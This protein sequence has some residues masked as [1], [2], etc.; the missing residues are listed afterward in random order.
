MLLHAIIFRPRAQVVISDKCG[1]SSCCGEKEPQACIVQE[2]ETHSTT[3]VLDQSHL[4]ADVICAELTA[5]EL[6]GRKLA[7]GVAGCPCEAV[8]FPINSLQHTREFTDCRWQASNAHASSGQ[9]IRR[10]LAL[11]HALG[12]QDLRRCCNPRSLCAQLRLCAQHRTAISIRRHATEYAHAANV[13]T[14]CATRA[15]A[16]DMS[17]ADAVKVHLVQW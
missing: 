9:H 12:N 4:H 8:A 13:R 15:R 5:V 17:E 3:I 2:A 10:T 7:C 11:T 16:C 6:E 14:A 1:A